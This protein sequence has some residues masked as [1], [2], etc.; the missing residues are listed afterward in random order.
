[1]PRA[2]CGF[3]ASEMRKT[4]KWRFLVVKQGHVSIEIGAANTLAVERSR[5]KQITDESDTSPLA[6]DGADWR[7]SAMAASKQEEE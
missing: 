6:P 3:M 7:L 2:A 4:N 5:P 1:M